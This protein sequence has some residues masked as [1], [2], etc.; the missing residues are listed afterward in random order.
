VWDAVLAAKALNVPEEKQAIYSLTASAKAR[1]E[2]QA[3]QDLEGDYTYDI[4]RD[5][6]FF[7]HAVLSSLTS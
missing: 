7:Q 5:T 4:R 2:R 6:S 3:S 1:L